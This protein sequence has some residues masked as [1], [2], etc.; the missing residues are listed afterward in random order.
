MVEQIR[1]NCGWDLNVSSQL[2]EAPPP[3]QEELVTLRAL[4]PE[5]FFIGQK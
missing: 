1:R 2:T 4:D 5:G 3:S